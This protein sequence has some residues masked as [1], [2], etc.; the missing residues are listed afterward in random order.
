ME[1]WFCHFN[2]FALAL[3]R[4]IITYLL[5]ALHHTNFRELDFDA[6]IMVSTN[7]PI[8]SE[9]VIIFVTQ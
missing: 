3:V 7:W 5:F 4:D 9:R 2:L 8:I 6:T 1:G